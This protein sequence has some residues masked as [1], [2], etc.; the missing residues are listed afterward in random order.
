MLLG[1]CLD[2][3]QVYFLLAGRLGLVVRALGSGDRV[4]AFES[5]PWQSVFF[6]CLF[7]LSFFISPLCALS[8]SQCLLLHAPACSTCNGGG[9]K[10]GITKKLSNA[11]CKANTDIRAMCGKGQGEGKSILLDAPTIQTM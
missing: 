1:L 6:C 9:K 8:P 4:H 11:I 10:R 7:L 2:T 5:R 3:Q